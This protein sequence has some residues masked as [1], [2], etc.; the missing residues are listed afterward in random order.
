VSRAYPYRQP[1]GCMA[2]DA[3]WVRLCAD[4]QR[5][6]DETHQRWQAERVERQRADERDQLVACSP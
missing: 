1:C 5:E 3:K 2:T 4:H 6:L